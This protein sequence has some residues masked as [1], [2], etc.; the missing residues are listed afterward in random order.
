MKEE[1]LNLKQIIALII[2]GLILISI[3]ILRPDPYKEK[4]HYD[5][6]QDQIRINISNERRMQTYGER[7]KTA[8]NRS[9]IEKNNHRSKYYF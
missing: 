4:D 2:M 7:K 9:S 8:R 1:K 3:F 5:Q 6:Q